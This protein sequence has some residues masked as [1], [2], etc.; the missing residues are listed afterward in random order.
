MITIHETHLLLLI[1]LTALIAYIVYSYYLDCNIECKINYYR[2][3]N[4]HDKKKIPDPQNLHQVMAK[5]LNNTLSID[6]ISND[7]DF[8]DENINTF[9]IGDRSSSHNSSIQ[10]TAIDGNRQDD[11][12]INK[13][14]RGIY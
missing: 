2:Y 8:K 5:D 6:S 9:D 13:F 1:V 11:M 10:S 7:I 12:Y 14:F 4:Y 3:E